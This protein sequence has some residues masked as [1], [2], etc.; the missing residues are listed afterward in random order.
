[1][2]LQK[3]YFYFLLDLLEANDQRNHFATLHNPSY[4]D[5]KPLGT[6]LSGKS[7][8]F[9]PTPAQTIAHTRVT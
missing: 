5:T 7:T 9:P 4:S 3:F 2:F 6:K 8:N 1:M